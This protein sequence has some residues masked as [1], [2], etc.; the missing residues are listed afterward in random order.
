MMSK[1]GANSH[2]GQEVQVMQNM[3]QVFSNLPSP[4]PAVWHHVNQ[5]VGGHLKINE[6]LKNNVPQLSV[7]PGGGTGAVWCGGPDPLCRNEA[8]AYKAPQRLL[9][10]SAAMASLV[11]GQDQR[12]V[13]PRGKQMTQCECVSAPRPHS[14]CLKHTRGPQLSWSS[15]RGA[16]LY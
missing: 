16:T 11:V 5:P 15:S 7:N 9:T 8:A 1:G 13:A 14:F 12:H 2:G 3:G 4:S 6:L 10:A